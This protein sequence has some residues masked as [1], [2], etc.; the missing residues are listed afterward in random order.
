MSLKRIWGAQAGILVLVLS[1]CSGLG[2]KTGG[3]RSSPSPE[4]SSSSV[5][6]TPATATIRAGSNESFAASV[7]GST[8]SNVTW[9]VNSVAGG[10]ATTGTID[11][12]GLYTAPTALPT[13]NT[14]TI[15]ATSAADTTQHVISADTL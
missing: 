7:S 1:G 5:T 15:T 4:G 12:N 8:N 13:P 9:S 3:G 10:S 6:V 11:A 14:V 2:T